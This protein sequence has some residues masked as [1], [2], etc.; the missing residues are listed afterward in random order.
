MDISQ[1]FR[2]KTRKELFRLYFTN[3]EQKYYLRELERS[4]SIP[5]SMIRSELLRLQEDGIFASTKQGNLTYYSLNQAYPLYEE[6]KSI[7]FKTIGIE[8]ELRKIVDKYKGIEQAFIYGSYAKNKEKKN[9]DVDLVLVGSFSRDEF[10]QEVRALEGKLKREIN[11]TAYLP[12]E[13][14][15]ESGKKGSFLDLVLNGPR[16]VLKEK[17][18]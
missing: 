3:P 6:L 14:L 4:L 13:F 17:R 9:S 18:A 8:G 12:Q 5:V 15:K 11:F 10:T 2:S 7:V 16:I 1:I